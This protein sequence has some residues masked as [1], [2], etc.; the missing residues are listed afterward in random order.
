M[1]ASPWSPR[2]FGFSAEVR[3]GCCSGEWCAARALVVTS[4]GDVWWCSHRTSAHAMS[5]RLGGLAPM[6]ADPN[7]HA[8]HPVRAA[9]SVRRAE[10]C[11]R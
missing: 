10:S 8:R 11:E 6:L 4:G 5:T 9:W 1:R 2:A 3:I 7:P